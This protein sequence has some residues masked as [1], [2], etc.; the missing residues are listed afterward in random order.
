[1]SDTDKFDLLLKLMQENK[2]DLGHLRDSNH[3]IRD[4]LHRVSGQFELVRQAQV[5]QKEDSKER[6]TRVHDRIDK[7]QAATKEAI[8]ERKKHIESIEK[9]VKDIA[10]KVNRIS[11]MFDWA[12]RIVITTMVGGIMW[13]TVQYMSGK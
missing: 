7:E 1:M 2:T 10:P 8:Q 4:E 11:N 13:A 3:D 5:T 12:T 6:F 9:I